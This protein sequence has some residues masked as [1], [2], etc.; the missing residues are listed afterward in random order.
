VGKVV[1]S[2]IRWRGFREG[3]IFSEKKGMREK[4]DSSEMVDSKGE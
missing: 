2:E 4:A 1:G 3:R